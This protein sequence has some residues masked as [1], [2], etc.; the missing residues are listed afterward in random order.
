MKIAVSVR[1]SGHRQVQTQTI[2]QQ[3]DRLSTHIQSQGQ[4]FQQVEIFR[5]DG[6]SGTSLKR[7]GLDRLCDQAARAAFDLVFITAPDRLARK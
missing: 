5:D 1:V 4:D 7:P 6:Y 2:E 3:L